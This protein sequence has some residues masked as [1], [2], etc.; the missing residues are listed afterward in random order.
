MLF[1]SDFVKGGQVTLDGEAIPVSSEKVSVSSLYPALEKSSKFIWYDPWTGKTYPLPENM[2]RDKFDA[3]PFTLKLSPGHHEL[4]VVFENTL[5]LDQD[6]YLNPVFHLTYLLQPAKYWA[7]FKNLQ[8]SITLP[9]SNYRLAGSLPLKRTGARTWTANFS[10]L[11]EKDLHLS[12]I[13]TSGMWL[14]P[15]TTK[16]TIWLLLVI[17]IFLPVFYKRFL[18]ARISGTFGFGLGIMLRILAAWFAWDTLTRGLLPAPFNGL[19]QIPLLVAALL[20]FLYGIVKDI[21]SLIRTSSRIG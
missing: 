12:V 10:K 8:I 18:A 1:I 13:S 15:Y 20:M 4:K 16:F 9:H 11:P 5:G 17:V 6:R 19:V 7:Y 2:R 14:G 21:Y 3:V